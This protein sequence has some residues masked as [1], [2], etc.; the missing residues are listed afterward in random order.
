MTTKGEMIRDVLDWIKGRVVSGQEVNWTVGITEGDAMIIG[1]VNGVTSETRGMT[2]LARAIAAEPWC[3]GLRGGVHLAKSFSKVSV[4]NHAEMCVLAAADSLRQRVAAMGCASPNCEACAHMLAFAG[5][6]SINGSVT[7][8]Q[9]GWVHPRGRMALGTQ[10]NPSWRE[11]IAELDRFNAAGAPAN[12]VHRYTLGL[13][14]DP[15]GA[16]EKI[17]EVVQGRCVTSS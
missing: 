7:G 5:V 16:T 13:N 15:E 3:T 4:S 2:D 12:F 1:R 6:K 10:L 9:Q 11:Q 17:V 8:G 14:A